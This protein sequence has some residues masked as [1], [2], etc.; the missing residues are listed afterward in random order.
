MTPPAEEKVSTE[1]RVGPGLAPKQIRRPTGT[2]WP[3]PGSLPPKPLSLSPGPHPRPE[4]SPIRP[5][6]H[7][8]QSPFSYTI[9]LHPRP[10]AGSRRAKGTSGA[11]SYRWGQYSSKRNGRSHLPAPKVLRFRQGAQDRHKEQ[12][13]WSPPG[14]QVEPEPALV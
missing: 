9:P 7:C 4:Q 14:A 8:Q 3:H 12:R 6:C 1:C 2:S 5:E 11:P 10:T 13:R